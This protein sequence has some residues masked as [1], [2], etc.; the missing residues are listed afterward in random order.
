[1]FQLANNREISTQIENEI[2]QE[3]TQYIAKLNI[4]VEVLQITVG[5]ITPPDQVLVET[6]NTAAQNQSILTQ[7]A[8]AH[9][10]L[11]RK[12]AEVNKAIADQAYQSQM[13]MT[14]DE[15]I[16]MRALEIEKEK[17]EL[18]KDNKN[19]SIIF[20]NASTSYQINHPPTR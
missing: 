14:I 6:R 18:I 5:A 10:E 20:G 7:Q 1:M 16:S 2:F 3:L 15:Y 9:A 17:V 11:A 19:I 12:A 8:R 13:N 4:P